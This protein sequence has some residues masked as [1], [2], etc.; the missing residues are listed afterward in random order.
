MF[1]FD[2]MEISV[3]IPIYNVEKYVLDCLLSVANQ[4]MTNGVECILVNDCGKDKSMTVVNNFL[5]SYKGRI[6][7]KLLNH[8]KNLGLSMARNSGILKA[9]GKYLFFLDSDDVLMPNCLE[10][11][12]VMAEKYKSDLVVGSYTVNSCNMERYDKIDLPEFTKNKSFI[13]RT[14][15]NYDKLQIMAQNKLVRR[16]F[17]LEHKLFFQKGIIHE[18]VL[19]TFFLAK[20]VERLAVC[21]EKVYYYRPTPGSITNNIN[22]PKESLSYWTMIKTF[23]ENLDPFEINVQKRLI[24]CL[25][26]IAVRNGYYEDEIAKENL[27]NCL[28]KRETFFNRILVFLIFHTKNPFLQLRFINLIMRIYEK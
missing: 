25:L 7:F 9:K 13:K 5:L 24:F 22:V 20:Y 23:A 12:Y 3:I 11:L 17:V 27:I 26:L 28:M 2:K 10:M 14:L 18:D 8:E 16:D 4:T 6:C 1:D 21:K 15:L 19:W